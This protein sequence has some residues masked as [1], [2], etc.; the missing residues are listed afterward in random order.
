MKP[1]RKI[2]R[3]AAIVLLAAMCCFSFMYM[4][5]FW[6]IDSGRS[7]TAEETEIVSR[8]LG[9]DIAPDDE[10]YPSLQQGF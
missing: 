10:F 4:F 7:L 1:V 9:F 6:I 5:N 2:I 8:M 3:I